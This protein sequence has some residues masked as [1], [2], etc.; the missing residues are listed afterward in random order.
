MTFA[1]H[2]MR[3]SWGVFAAP[4]AYVLAITY[5]VTNQ[6]WLGAWMETAQTAVNSFTLALPLVVVA[7]GLDA[8]RDRDPASPLHWSR[9]VRPI[10]QIVAWRWLAAYAWMLAAFISVTLTLLALTWSRSS[11]VSFPWLIIAVG[12][13]WIVAHAAL[14]VALGELLPRIWFLV[15]GATVPLLLNI[16]LAWDTGMPSALL[17]ALD[18]GLIPVGT[19]LA[20]DVGIRQ[21]LWFSLLSVASLVAATLLSSIWMR[22]LLALGSLVL[23][24]AVVLLGH[25]ERAAP[26]SY[27]RSEC[28]EGRVRICVWQEQAY[29]L[30]MIAEVIDGMTHVMPDSAVLPEVAVSSGLS[31]G[32]SGMEFYVGSNNPDVSGTSMSIATDLLRWM[33]CGGGSGDLALE[34]SALAREQWLAWHGSEGT[35]FVTVDEVSRV[36]QEPPSVQW[37]WF[38]QEHHQLCVR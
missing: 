17:T 38:E 23:G 16:R 14:G 33:A 3:S 28:A 26:I 25:G 35:S 9:G 15:I 37:E 24:V 34:E 20:T 29:Y 6:R 13:T 27:E 4:I 36:L 5:A 21:M 18:N 32:P 8:R 10:W 31:P 30:P 19:T 1:F 11:P 22:A 12:C 2:A 7:A